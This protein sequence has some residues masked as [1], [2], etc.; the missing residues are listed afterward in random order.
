MGLR[1]LSGWSGRGRQEVEKGEQMLGDSSTGMHTR[2]HSLLTTD[3][4]LRTGL[5]V[6]TPQA[7][8]A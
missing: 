7:D 8:D 2:A 4:S 6:N 1:E 3:L 5:G